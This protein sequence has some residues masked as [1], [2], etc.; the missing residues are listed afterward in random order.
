MVEVCEGHDVG[1]NVPEFPESE[2]SDAAAD[3]AELMLANYAP[4]T[5][6]NPFLPPSL[7][8]S[9]ASDST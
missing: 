2:R 7:V 9:P 5:T 1:D 6:V 3:A 4:P 8:Q